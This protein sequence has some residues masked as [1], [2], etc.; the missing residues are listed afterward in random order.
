MVTTEANKGLVLV[1][2][3]VEQLMAVPP[4]VSSSQRNV[5]KGSRVE[6]RRAQP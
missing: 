1:V 2:D 3:K 5:T 4:P 6:L